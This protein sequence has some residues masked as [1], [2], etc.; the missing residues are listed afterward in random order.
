MESRAAYAMGLTPNNV[1]PELEEILTDLGFDLSVNY[2]SEELYRYALTDKKIFGDKI[3][4]VI[5]ESI[6]KCRLQ[7][8]SLDKLKEFIELGMK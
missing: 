8:I 2:S 5:P 1:S 6:G 4:M 7:K 3:S